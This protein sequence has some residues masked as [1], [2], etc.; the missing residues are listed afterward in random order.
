M[1][2]HSC[3]LC[4]RMSPTQAVGY[5]TQQLNHCFS[6]HRSEI[7]NS[8]LTE[9]LVKHFVN[10]TVT[11]TLICVCTFFWRMSPTQA[12]GYTTQQLN[13]R[14]SSHRSEINNSN[15]TRELVKH[16][17]NTTVTLTLICVCTF[18]SI[19]SEG[20][21]LMTPLPLSCRKTSG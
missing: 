14:F 6:S 13:H 2:C 20:S 19:F 10:T 17:V 12:V 16:F 15:L 4:W 21:S 8:N 11:L 3:N 1:F 7:N 18:F 9:E 5:T